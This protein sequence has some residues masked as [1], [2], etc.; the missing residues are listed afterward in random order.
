MRP[1]PT[2]FAL[3][4]LP[5]AAVAQTEPS[6]V[7]M[8]QASG[9]VLDISAQGR[10]SRVP[11]VATIR[12]GVVTQAPTAAAALADQAARMSRVLAALRRAGVQPR[13][14]ATANV[15]LSPQ[16]RYV[17]NQPP[18]ITGYQATNTVAIRFREIAKAGG[19]LDALVAAGANQIDGPEL[20]IDQPDAALDEARL[21]AVK[22]A[23]AR[24]ELYA[25]AA[26]LRVRRIVSIVE[27]G[28]DAG[29]PRPP[30][31]Y[32]RMASADA[33]T[34]VVAGERDL[35]VTVQVRFLLD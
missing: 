14:I 17:E 7:P 33:K 26:G 18:A 15:G 32:A 31:A 24:A 3:A 30:I 29:S 12:A 28:V 1:T 4:L 5:A 35:G 21:E 16:Y 22:T 8:V 25:R 9:T 20:A 10:V 19:I 6:V 11:D 27:A 34:E 23:R 2:M 13:D